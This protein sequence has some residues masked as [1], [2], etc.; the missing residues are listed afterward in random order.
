MIHN[1]QLPQLSI[2]KNLIPKTNKEKKLSYFINAIDINHNN[3]IT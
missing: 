1:I 2:I 3:H